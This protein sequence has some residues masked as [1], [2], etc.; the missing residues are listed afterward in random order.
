MNRTKRL[1]PIQEPFLTL[2]ML[3]ELKERKPED[4]PTITAE[5]YDQDARQL[6]ADTP[7]TDA[8][9]GPEFVSMQLAQL[10]DNR[11]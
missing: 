3:R 8:V 6:C 5:F 1:T 2:L 10:A 9:I 7:L 4:F 11:S